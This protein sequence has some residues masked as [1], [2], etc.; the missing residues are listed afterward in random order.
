ML[1]RLAVVRSS[2]IHRVL[3]C[4][5]IAA[6]LGTP[7][8]T[9]AAE[10]SPKETAERPP[11]TA[12]GSGVT[13]TPISTRWTMPPPKPGV[14]I[15]PV[16][17]PPLQKSPQKAGAADPMRVEYDTNTHAAISAVA[18]RRPDCV[19]DNY[20]KTRLLLPSGINTSSLRSEER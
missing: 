7:A 8:L 14:K 1:P 3:A 16:P 6:H 12:P 2:P 13:T 15:E 9:L 19:A 5:V 11:A 20:L 18:I 4:L 10:A 17:G